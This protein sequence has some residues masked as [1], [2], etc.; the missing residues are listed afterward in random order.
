[1]I[2]SLKFRLREGWSTFFL[3]NGMLL[4][5]AW[6]IQAAGWTAGLDR[7]PW[8]IVVAL[9]LGLLLTKSRLSDPS[10]HI[11]S[12][13]FG[14]C[15]AV[16]LT[17]TLLPGDLSWRQRIIE[18]AERLLTWIEKALSGGSSSDNLLFVLQLAVLL[19]W[20]AYS[21]AW[22]TF[23]WPR[24]WWVLIPSGLAMFFNLYWAP[25]HLNLYFA[26]Y[27]F[28]ALLLGVRHNVHLWEWKWQ[29]RGISYKPDIGSHF[30][31]AGAIF[32][33][34]VLLAVW[35]LPIAGVNARLIAVWERFHDPWQGLRAY[36]NRL[37]SALDYYPP[38][39]NG[40]YSSFSPPNRSLELGGPLQLSDEPL[41][42]IWA[43][44]CGYWRA[45]VYDTYT[46]RQWI[47]T[48]RHMTSLEAGVYLP[49]T[50]Y[51]L[52]R[53]V[54]HTVRLLRGGTN[55][56]HVSSQPLRI[57]LPLWVV[58]GSSSIE[59]VLMLYSSSELE[60]DQTYT[61]VSSVS[62]ADVD[63][64]RRA[65]N[66]Y[67]AW[68][69]D[70]YLQLPASLS[71][72]V[73]NLAQNLT[74]RYDNAYDKIEALE[75]HLRHIPYDEEIEAPPE[76]RDSVD[77]FLFEARQGYCS[78]YASALVVMARALGIPARPV[79]GYKGERYS[80]KTG[81]CRVLES[82]AH[83]WAEVYFPDYGWIEF[84]PTPSE[85]LVERP[86]HEGQ[87]QTK[88]EEDK[89][90]DHLRD[91]QT[92]GLGW[93]GIDLSS[94]LASLTRW[95]AEQRTVYWLGMGILFLALAG[96][97]TILWWRGR[98]NQRTLN[99]AEQAY[100]SLLRWAGR[101]GLARQAFQTPHEHA[102]LLVQA[103]PRGREPLRRLVELYV[104]ERFGAAGLN[105]A[106]QEEAR[107]VWHRLR[108]ILRS[109]LWRQ[110]LRLP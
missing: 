40:E 79:S 109:H 107:Q 56:I 21:C 81:A 25:T 57:N 55:V 41:M 7:L 100:I 103:L 72:R 53:E 24:I 105:E 42:D 54:N 35:S 14:A 31:R 22:F 16:Y 82:D 33:L 28:C 67:P 74:R 70:R 83:A 61:V 78:Y 87:T 69:T 12:A 89:P 38:R 77:Y 45:E 49:Q 94:G 5:V 75:T 93:G 95:G 92:S 32:A 52:R 63:S 98:A 80:A 17:G 60:R 18:L 51:K 85:P 71:R 13:L 64:L 65:G 48:A 19:W 102:G 58:L 10:I 11:L 96:S 30:L 39:Q 90:G 27:L 108:P 36:W 9:A 23:R 59:N 20:L 50:D 62:R 91:S 26:L 1:M 46:G 8:V 97:G 3:L 68:V 106:E 84:E 15:W 76:G 104:K 101:L 2:M 44:N 29:A 88:P 6:S 4:S 86:E 66:E 99:E 47:N 34:C 110:R 37:Y 43:E 73:R